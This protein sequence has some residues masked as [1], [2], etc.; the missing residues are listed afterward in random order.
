M[1]TPCTVS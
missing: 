1:N